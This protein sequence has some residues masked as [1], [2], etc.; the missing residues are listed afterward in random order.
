[1][2]VQGERNAMKIDNECID[3]NAL[4]LI[5]KENDSLTGYDEKDMIYVSG[6]INGILEMAEAMKEVLKA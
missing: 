2:E 5:E 4:R 3:Y 6:V 1:M